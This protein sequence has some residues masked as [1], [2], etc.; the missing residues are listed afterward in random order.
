MPK[1]ALLGP[2]IA[3][4]IATFLTKKP[5]QLKNLAQAKQAR[6]ALITSAYLANT[7]YLL[8]WA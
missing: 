2:T 4:L 8:L 6:C 3:T 7:P 5:V 1:K